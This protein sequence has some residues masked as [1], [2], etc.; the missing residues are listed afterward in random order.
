MELV[1]L[2]TLQLEE[3]II[4]NIFYS[5][6]S[7]DVT[8]IKKYTSYAKDRMY[9]KWFTVDFSVNDFIEESYTSVTTES[10]IHFAV[11]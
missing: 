5:N 1:Q 2:R 8:E 11:S 4:F 3:L 7:K 9:Q 10:G 6:K